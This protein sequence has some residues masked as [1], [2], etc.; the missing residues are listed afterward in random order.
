MGSFRANALEVFEGITSTFNELVDSR[1][2]N[3]ESAVSDKRDEFYAAA[4][5]DNEQFD[6]EI[7]DLTEEFQA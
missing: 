4:L 2:A 6:K 5:D 7:D 1:I 3:W